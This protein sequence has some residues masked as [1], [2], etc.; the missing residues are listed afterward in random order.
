MCG[1]EHAEARTP[2]HTWKML[3]DIVVIRVDPGS[4]GVQRR[5]DGLL[6]DVKRRTAVAARRTCFL[7][8]RSPIHE[9]WWS[10]TGSNRRPPACKA[11]ALP[12]ELWPRQ[13]KAGPKIRLAHAHVVGPGRLELPTPRLSS[14]CSNQLSY[15]PSPAAVV[16][17][18]GAHRNWARNPSPLPGTRSRRR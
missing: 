13:R 8:A 11:G 16:R 14:V 3:D 17:W 10:Q 15:G 18:L 5:I 2:R 1:E 7:I 6:H 4:A 9:K 12:T